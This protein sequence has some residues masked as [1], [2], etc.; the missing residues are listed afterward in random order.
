MK[1]AILGTRGIPNHY[2][3]FEQFAEI[4]SVNLVKLGH[5]ITVYN[6]HFHSYKENFF[7][8]VKIKRAYSPEKYIGAAA[9]FIYDYLCFRDALK[10]DF[11]IILE[12]GYHSNAPSYYLMKKTTKPVL[13]TNMDGIEWKRS[14]WNNF[15]R[16]LIEKL[17]KL[18]VDKSDYL[19]SDNIGIQKYYQKKYNVDS[20]C[21]AYG[22]DLINNFNVGLLEDYKVESQKYFILIA[23]LEP[24]NNIETILDAFCQSQSD[25]PFLVIGNYNTKYGDYVKHKYK[26]NKIFFCGGIYDKK[27]LD[28]LRKYALAYFHGHSVGGTNPSLLEAMASQAFIVAHENE[29]NQSILEGNA[30]Y[31]KGKNDLKTIIADLSSFSL[32]K[33]QLFIAN[34]CI[35][36]ENRYAWDLI[37]KEYETLFIKVLKEKGRNV[38]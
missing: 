16:K 7:N 29:F 18:A 22:A 4:I 37:T 11:D 32:T 12:C 5:E 1:I 26:N 36:I 24:E 6:P 30:L 21:I 34:N 35:A 14:K 28:S 19:V 23:R 31:F 20:Y 9:N 27:R 13:I 3:G 38:G 33:R 15:T 2:G 10:S 8:D 25:F 17:E